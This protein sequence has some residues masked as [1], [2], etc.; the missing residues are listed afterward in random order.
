MISVDFSKRSQ[1]QQNLRSGLILL[2]LLLLIIWLALQYSDSQ[3][4]AVSKS[5][6]DQLTPIVEPQQRVLT[7]E[8]QQQNAAAEE[9]VELLNI[10]WLNM[11]TDLESVLASVPNIYLKQLQPNSRA[12]QII[13]SGEA[14]TLEP[15]LDLM[16]QLES[17]SAF[18]DVLLM[19]QHQLEDDPTRLGFTLKMG[20]Q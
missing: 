11:L 2:V 14:D 20:W 1:H 4:Q 10:P 12:G 16:Q 5:N 3:S 15:L 7:A 8:E 6:Q 17:E 13:I 19:Q 9:L 18:N